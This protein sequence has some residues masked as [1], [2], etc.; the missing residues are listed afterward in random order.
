MRIWIRIFIWCGCGYGSGSRLPKWC[1]SLRIRIN[2]IERD[3]INLS[4]SWGFPV[5]K[6]IINLSPSTAPV[7]TRQTKFN[8]SQQC[9]G[10]GFRI[11]CSFWPRGL[12]FGMG[13][14]SRSVSGMNIPDHIYESWETIFWGKKYL[15]SLMQIRNLFDPGSGINIMDLQHCFLDMSKLF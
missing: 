13:K 9:C 5:N 2:N 8:P 6:A 4:S 7:I 15:N 11:R 14:K 1:G 12:G 10:S 3:A